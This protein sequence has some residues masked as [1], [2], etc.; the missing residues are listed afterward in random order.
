VISNKEA[1]EIRRLA[2]TGMPLSLIAL[3]LNRNLGTVRKW[4]LTEPT[5][6]PSMTKPR[7]YRTRPDPFESIIAE[8]TD[9]LEVPELEAK[10]IF[11]ELQDKYPGQFPPGQLRTFQRRVRVWRARH[12]AEKEVFFEQVLHPGVQG[13]SDFTCMNNLAITINGEQFPHMCYHFVLP[14]SNWEYAETAYSESYAALSRGLQNAL[15]VLGGAPLEHRTDNLSAATHNLGKEGGRAFN[16][17][18]QR[19]V[20]HYRMRPSRNN[21]GRGNENGDVEKGHDVFK[22][23]LA[24][25][26]LLR[27]SRDFESHEAYVVFRSASLARCNERR[28]ERVAEE[29][30][31]LQ[32]LPKMR[33][34]DYQVCEARVTRWSTVRVLENAYS[35]PATLIGSILR[36]HAHADH[37]EVFHGSALVLRVDRLHGRKGARINYRHIIGWLVR[38]PG[39]FPNY[40][41]REEL[42]PRLVFRL[43]FDALEQHAPSRAV[44]EYLRI[45]KLA[46]EYLE[47]RVAEELEK[48]LAQGGLPS[49][50]ELRKAIDPRPEAC[51]EVNVRDPN[52]EGYDALIPE[53]A[54]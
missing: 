11:Q 22:S 19:L 29:A 1:L 45:L 16:A 49:S 46:A 9:R 37:L 51:P 7:S 32:A 41:Y 20:A 15:F 44:P 35:V 31:H 10:T 34:E 4:I 52:L 50:E 28:R 54:A 43:A 12:G 18:Y 14:W 36:V 23:T 3:R 13:Q 48:T 47:S 33:L 40:Q 6:I 21:P 24:Q 25:Q 5:R 53:D 26:L 42:F 39:A 30:K 8:I 38:K 17:R 27:G 2:G